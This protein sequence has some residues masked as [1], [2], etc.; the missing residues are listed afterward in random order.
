MQSESA[1]FVLSF[2]FGDGLEI[3][4]LFSVP[5]MEAVSMIRG[6][7]D[8]PPA[9]LEQLLSRNGMDMDTFLFLCRY[10]ERLSA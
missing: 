10:V 1:G 2:L 6:R 4:E 8:I 5:F 3:S 9:R 7:S